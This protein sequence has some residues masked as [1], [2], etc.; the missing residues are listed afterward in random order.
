MCIQCIALCATNEVQYALLFLC[1]LLPLCS[2]CFSLIHRGT[3]DDLPKQQ[4]RSNGMAQTWLDALPSHAVF[5]AASQPALSLYPG[6]QL[7]PSPGLS[8]VASFHGDESVINSNTG[9]GI[10]STSSL[11]LKHQAT[12]IVRKT[13]LL[14]AV[15]SSIRL[16]DLAHF[17]TRIE[18]NTAVSPADWQQHAH[19]GTWNDDSRSTV[20]A[21]DLT[22]AGSSGLGSFKVRKNWQDTLPNR[23]C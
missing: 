6:E 2:F 13:E 17:K 7:P 22:A 10:A 3:G 12:C 23:A 8:T 19:S 18:G 4:R 14:V 20:D 21:A 15:A 9:N 16:A 5:R 11:K 1:R